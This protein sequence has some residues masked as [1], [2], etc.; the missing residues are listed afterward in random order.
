MK[1]SE[2]AE[3]IL[4]VFCHILPAEYVEAVPWDKRSFMF[5]R[6]VSIPVMVDLEARFRVMDKFPGYRQ[7]PSLASPLPEQ[8]AG[9][10]SSLDLARKANDAMAALCGRH[11]ERFEGFVAALPL[12]NPDASMAEAERAVDQ[13]G[14]AGVQI[15]TSVDGK[16]VDLPEYLQLFGLMAEK[17]RAVWLHPVRP[18][19]RP[20]YPAEAVSKFDI[21]WSLGWPFETS[22]AMVRLVFAGLFDR[23]PG[24]VVI[25]HHVGGMIPMMEGRMDSGMELLGTR[26]PKEHA[27]AVRHQ[28]RMKPVEALRRFYADTASFGS[29]IAIEAGKQFFGLEQLMFA[30]DMPFDPEGGPGYIRGTLKA[31]DTMKLSEQQRRAILNGN[32]CRALG[33]RRQ[34]PG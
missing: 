8:L 19:T 12:N 34:D 26:T 32:A 4:D 24:L 18:M 1:F 13:L 14:A 33:C 6:A 11:P 23:W 16:P 5:Q 31:L 30:T 27:E 17:G 29:A 15:T 3:G 7:V 20:E 9:P 25:T 21:W 2:R 22:A 10:E 28:L